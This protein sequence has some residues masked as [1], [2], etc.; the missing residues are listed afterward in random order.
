MDWSARFE[1]FVA[2]KTAA[3]VD[4]HIPGYQTV[5]SHSASFRLSAIGSAWTMAQFDGRFFESWPSDRSLP[6]I[7]CVFVQSADGNTG[8]DRPITLGGGL[9]DKHLIYEGLSS[10]HADAILTGAAT[11]R[12]EQ[13]VMALW[14]PELVAL[15]TGLGLP[16]Y[17]AQIVATR[18]GD[19]EIDSSLLYNLPHLRVFILTNDA[20]ADTM[21]PHTVSRPWIHVLSGGETSDL[22]GGLKALRAHHG[23]SRVSSIA[24]RTV[25]TQLMDAGVVQDLYLTTSPRPGGEPNT[26]FYTGS[27]PLPTS[28]VL[29]KAGRDS[30]AGVTFEH[31]LL[32][33]PNS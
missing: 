10:V 29:G 16:R 6:A 24:G 28:L 4:A 22:I 20:G 12:G 15:R 32:N 2:K 30:E 3:A 27:R 18:S 26:P 7:N 19:L 23:I 25:A 31:L 9:T 17:P 5:V 21:R 11:I 14:H 13:T 8:A 1:A 33:P